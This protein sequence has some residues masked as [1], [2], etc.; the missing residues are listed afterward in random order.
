MIHTLSFPVRYTECDRYNH[1]NH[2]HYI[3]YMGEAAFSASSMVGYSD[4]KL[5]QTDLLW[6]TREHEIE[7]LKP[8]RFG[9]MVEVDTWVAD[10]QR[11]R[12]RR[13]YRLFRGKGGQNEG[14]R[15]L[16]ARA[17]TDWVLLNRSTGRPIKVPEQMV[18]DFMAKNRNDGAKPLP[19]RSKFPPSPP[20]PPNV[21]NIVMPVEWRDIDPN[22]HVNNAAYFSYIENGVLTF[23]DQLGW[24]YERMEKEGFGIFARRYRMAYLKPIGIGKK[25]TLQTWVTDFKRSMATRH[26][27]LLDTETGDLIVQ[28]KCLWVWVDL[29]KERPIRIPDH[30]IRDFADNFLSKTEQAPLL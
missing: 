24:P 12:S 18:A 19:P 22:G 29:E 26:Y 1:V 7:F 21:G 27:R 11:V 20:M 3:R 10:F 28:G 16:M 14:E 25:M 17:T 9:D 4:H 2:A 6:I 13:E 5:R 30:F 23:C 8:F 15:E